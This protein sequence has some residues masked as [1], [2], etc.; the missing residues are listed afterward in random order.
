[1][2]RQLVMLIAALVV[3]GGL[4]AVAPVAAED[5]CYEADFTYT[6]NSGGTQ[7]LYATP[8][9]EEKQRFTDSSKQFA[10]LK[11][12]Q[13]FDGTVQVEADTDSGDIV[14]F[15]TVPANGRDD[16]DNVRANLIG[17]SSL[18]RCNVFT[19]GRLNDGDAAAPIVVYEEDEF[20]AF[21]FYS[22]GTSGVG[23]EILRVP[24]ADI[25][26]PLNTAIQTGEN[27]LIVDQSG[28]AVYALSAGTCQ[29][30]VFLPGNQLYVFEWRCRRALTDTA[31]TTTTTTTT[32][33]PTRVVPTPQPGVDT[34]V[35]GPQ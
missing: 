16:V 23:T 35:V 29:V 12:G 22:V 15:S 25:L 26:P 20:A 5:I 24:F 27:Q 1:M 11:N 3:V 19:D 14:L 10:E 32:P 30:N 18:V 31:T 6:N 21:S 7:K 28:L 34:I 2:M 17:T 4:W 13:E 33:T 9:N 8:F